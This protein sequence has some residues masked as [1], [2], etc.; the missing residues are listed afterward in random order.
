M[1]N[2][3]PQS[4]SFEMNTVES[5]EGPVTIENDKELKLPSP[6]AEL[7]RLHHKY[8]HVSMARLQL[9]SRQGMLPSWLAKCNIP[10][11][12]ACLYSK[13]QRQPWRGKTAKNREKPR[14]AEKPG[15]RMHSKAR[16]R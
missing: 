7:L 15:Y 10:A 14:E 4:I 3:E 12:A 2:N 9:M 16:F 11:C 13:A 8:N 6:E 1:A 5:A